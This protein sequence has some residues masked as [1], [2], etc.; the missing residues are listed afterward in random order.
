ML[1]AWNVEG[2][3]IDNHNV[4]IEIIICSRGFGWEIWSSIFGIGYGRIELGQEM[5]IRTGL[6]A[7]G[8]PGSYKPVDRIWIYDRWGVTTFVSIETVALR[9]NV[10]DMLEA[11]FL[12]AKYSVLLWDTAFFF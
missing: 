7:S 3:S 12:Q 1:T 8:L 4:G 10:E 2:I 6:R 11:I 5:L 9:N